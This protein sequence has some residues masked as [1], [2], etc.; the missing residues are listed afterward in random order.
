MAGHMSQLYFT[1][2][3]EAPIERF[4]VG[5]T[6]K[7]WYKVLFLPAALKREL[8]FDRYPRLRVD[9]EIA[10]VPVNGA[11]IPA[12][13]GRH[14][15]IVAPHVFKSA[16]VAMGDCVEM[17]FRIDDQDRVAPP[18]ALLQAIERHA[19]AKTIWTSLTP[20]KKRAL[21]H[22]VGT[23]KTAPTQRKRIDEAIAALT[24][25]NGMLRKPRA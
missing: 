11:W 22:H 16:S 1:H 3:F 17:R 18:D 8:P 14:Y 24:E 5:K 20:G 9:G 12:G 21:A 6:R 4:G 19:A 2:G 7:V 23:A 15:F 10:D 25:R 13:D